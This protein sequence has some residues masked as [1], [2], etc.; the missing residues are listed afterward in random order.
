VGATDG[1]APSLDPITDLQI[2]LLARA[3]ACDLTRF[4]TLMLGDLSHTHLFPE[5]PDDI[6]GDVAHRY[7]ART[8]R[9]P[10]TPET[11]RALGIQNQYSYTKVARL[12]MRLDE[13]GVLDDTIVF[14]SGEM[15]DPSRHSS[16]DVPS[17]L[18]GGCGGKFKMGRTV[19]LR[20]EGIVEGTPNNRVLVSI[21][22]AFGVEIDRFGYSTDPGVITGELSL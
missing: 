14:C 13:A 7:D 10:G 20:R 12:L 19:S 3:F 4:A 1:G 5:L 6:H 17:I 11:W 8:E 16:R 9:R 21:A 15:G 18:A 2:D 22:R